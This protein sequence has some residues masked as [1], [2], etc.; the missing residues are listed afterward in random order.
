MLLQLAVGPVCLFVLNA[1]FTLGFRRA[2]A[3]VAAVALVDA[4]YIA[5]SA[6][7]AAA[8]LS[9]P[10]ARRIARATGA[11][12]LC[13]FGADALLGALGVSLLPG[14]RLFAPSQSGGL[15]V[16]ALLLTASNPLTILFWGGALAARVAEN[17]WNRGQLFLFSMGCVLATALFLNAVAALGGALT[18]KLPMFAIQALNALVGAALIAFGLRLL[19]RKEAKRQAA[20][21]KQ[22]Q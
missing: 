13:L 12:V 16:Q 4:A 17:Q 15:F 10:G 9:K 22:T 14:V 6:V 21:G 19:L 20:C 3:A 7:G 1:S 2:L 11:A 8:L 18:G 5:L